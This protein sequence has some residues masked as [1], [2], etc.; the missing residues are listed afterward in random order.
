M[1]TF[2][3]AALATTLFAAGSLAEP[4]TYELSTPGVV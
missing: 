4:V 1:K 3:L 2:W